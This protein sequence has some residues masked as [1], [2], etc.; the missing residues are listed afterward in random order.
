DALY[1]RTG[2]W[3]R[4]TFGRIPGTL[5]E[6]WS[7]VNSALR[8][9][10]RGL[11]GGS[12]LARLLAEHRGVRNPKGLRPYTVE[13]ILAW[14]DAHHERTG[15]W[16]TIHSGPIPEA[17]GETWQ[18]VHAALSNGKR[19]MPGG[20]SLPRLLAVERGARN[21]HNLPDLTPKQI[22]RWIDA[23]QRRTGEWPTKA[24]GPIPEAPGETWQTVD[25]SLREGV[26]GLSARS[27]LAQ[28]LAKHR[29]VRNPKGLPPLRVSQILTWADAYR[30]RTGQWPTLHSGPI[31]EAPGE[32]W[33][34]VDHALRHGVRSLPSGSSLARLLAQ[35]RGV[36]NKAAAPP[37]T[38]KQIL[39]WADAHYCQTGRWPRYKDGVITRVPQE[40]WNGVDAALRA[41]GRGLPGGSS[42]ARLL[43]E[44][45][46]VRNKK[47]LPRL[48]VQQILAWADAHYRRT[49]DWPTARSGPV[50]DAPGETWGAIDMALY[51]ASR[52]LPGGTS[53][54]RLLEEHGRLGQPGK[55]SRNGRS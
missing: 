43:A 4:R 26:R 51:R 9:G 7:A 46:G 50:A 49:G 14:A 12:S 17:P 54:C 21:I 45:R 27:S 23:Y 39:A 35:K 22:L 20:S 41:G 5:G 29:G 15:H 33:A 8:A 11:P 10:L 47:D 42:L 24:S 13:Q 48:T 6:T 40:T 52:G 28:L 37:L 38:V 16:P 55:Q 32:D 19:G 3:P 30:A 36:R 25:R 34:A 18:A 53:L 44:H 1:E 2:L 31:P